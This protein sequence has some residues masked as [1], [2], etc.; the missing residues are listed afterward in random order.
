[1]KTPAYSLIIPV[2]NRPAEL[3]ELLACIQTLEF[4]NFEVIVIDDGSTDNTEEVVAILGKE[5]E[6]M[7]SNDV[8]GYNTVMYKWDGDSGFGANMNGMFQN[9]KLVQKA[10]FGLN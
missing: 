8:A 5:G 7:S 2:Y 10:Q 6:E 9:G 1:M 4:K 3:D